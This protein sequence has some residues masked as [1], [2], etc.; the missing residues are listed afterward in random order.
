MP[1]VLTKSMRCILSS[2]LVAGC[3]SLPSIALAQEADEI[4]EDELWEDFGESEDPWEPVNRAIFTFNDTL[5]RWALKPLATGYRNLTPDVIEDSVHNVFRNLG[6]V[7]NLANNILQFKLHDAGVDTA[8]FF[9]NTTFGV[10]GIFDV[11][12]KMGLQRN[13]EDFG[14]T[15]GAWGVKSGPYVVLPLLG[16]STVRDTVALYPDSF[17]SQ[18]RYINDVPAR[19][20]IFALN[21]VDSRASLLIAE[22]LIAGDKY[23]FVRNAFLQNREFKVLDGNVVDD[24]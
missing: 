4:Y 23:R 9:F 14:Q 5:D 22:R 13:A 8:R 20:S 16:P 2:V 6:E 17:T 24:F 15:L 11:A 21:V 10:L 7:S 12:T 1:L 3:L 18:Y 19:N